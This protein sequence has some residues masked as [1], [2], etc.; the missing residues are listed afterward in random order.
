MH[1]PYVRCWS[2]IWFTSCSNEKHHVTMKS[3]LEHNQSLLSPRQCDAGFPPPLSVV[4]C[5]WLNLCKCFGV[6][7]LPVAWCKSLP[8][9]D[10]WEQQSC[11]QSEVILSDLMDPNGRKTKWSLE[12]QL[13]KHF[14]W[15]GGD[16][17]GRV[18]SMTLRG[19]L[20]FNPVL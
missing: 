1:R 19:Q 4:L 2:D 16:L 5:F 6:F 17:I 8:H 7:F 12:I 3:R 10:K 15:G 18:K 20:S 13:C 11:N 9:C 14:L